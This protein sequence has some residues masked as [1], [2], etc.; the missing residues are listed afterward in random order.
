MSTAVIP[1][2]RQAAGTRP[3]RKMTV[4]HFPLGGV[5]RDFVMLHVASKKSPVSTGDIIG[6]AT[7]L[8]VITIFLV[9]W[10]KV[11][12]PPVGA[13][14]ITLL[15]LVAGL[16]A[17]SYPTVASQLYHFTSGKIGFP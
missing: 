4:K 7:V 5:A 12:L 2:V 17:G 8:I 15:P 3:E 11:K 13:A 1:A 10:K 16:L 9:L 14:V 6:I